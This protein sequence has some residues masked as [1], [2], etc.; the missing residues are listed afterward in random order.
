L[1]TYILKQ[2]SSKGKKKDKSSKKSSK[3]E[4]KQRSDETGREKVGKTKS[5]GEVVWHTDTT[6]EAVK[7]R[8]EKEFAQM[9]KGRKEVSKV[10][11][12]DSPLLVLR[13]FIKTKEPAE[14]LILAELKRLQLA[15][16]FTDTEKV[17]ILVN[18][19]IDTA[20]IKT[21]AKQF[22]KNAGLYRKVIVNEATADLFLLCIEELVGVVEKGLLKRTPILLQKLYESDVLEED[23]ILKWAD[24]PA[25][26]SL[27][28]R[29]I[30]TEVR[31]AAGPFVKWLKE[32]DSDSD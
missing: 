12:K 25:E 28:S 9:S 13:D 8:K 20:E 19:T 26:T 5:A 1:T 27:V 18:A 3:K 15:R 24:A 32:A 21:V 7:A 14:Q 30:A 16:G 22:E 11:A 4:R 17:K 23:S 2:R 31:K 29:E 6:E 10:S